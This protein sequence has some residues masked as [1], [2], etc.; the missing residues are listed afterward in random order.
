MRILLIGLG[1]MGKNHN[2][3]LQKLQSK[4]KFELKTCDIEE[5]SDYSDY[6]EGYEDFKPT[7]VIIATPTPT[8]GELLQYFKDKKLSIFVEKPIV[9]DGSEDAYMIWGRNIMV[10]HIERYNPMIRTL[11]AFLNNKT[12]DTIITIRSGLHQVEEDNNVDKDLAIHDVDVI[13]FITK[14]LKK[15]AINDNK[16][17]HIF[18]KVIKPNFSDIFTEINGVCCFIHADKRSPDK[19]RL[20]KVF[21][22]N[23][24]LEGNYMSQELKLNGHSVPINKEEP[25]KIELETFLNDEFTKEDLIDAINNIKILNGQHIGYM[26]RNKWI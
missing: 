3:V 17:S 24:I 10:G 21:G 4:Y 22:P 15:L 9:D 14:H 23:Y 6:E 13:Q 19:A 16:S 1:N 26:R 11:K 8:H 18:N 20:I 5:K 2:R 25:L 12:I 7:H